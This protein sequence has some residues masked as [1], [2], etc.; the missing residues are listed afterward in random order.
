MKKGINFWS[1]ANGTTVKEAMSL[2]KAAGFDGIELALGE[3]GLV[4]MDV[5]GAGKEAKKMAEDIGIE[6]PSLACGQC[7]DYL[8]TS[9]DT[10]IRNKAKDL[11]RR[12]A[13]MAAEIGADT[14]LVLAGAVGVDF[15]PDG[16]G[17]LLPYDEAYGISLESLEEL[18]V[19]AEKVKINF[20]VENVWNKFL[21][22]PI[23][24]RDFI[25]KIG[26]EYVGC[27]FDVGNVIL[28]GYPEQWI[29]ILGKRIKKVHFKDYRRD[30]GGFNCFVDLL[31]GDVNY[32]AVIEALE[33]VGYD[34]YCTAEMIPNYKYYNS[35]TIFNASA[36]MDR[37][38]KKK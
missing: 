5:P 35:Q 6:L 18:A 36:S 22:S 25:D 4:G 13:D 29:R 14:I 19:Y 16:G 28:T 21:L 9:C 11:S 37:I 2:A 31:S 10:D 26:S 38:L 7:W 33:S 15:L 1:F 32:P 17:D 27:Y 23:E 20:A 3:V 24:F 8:L 12:Q 34:D 30:P